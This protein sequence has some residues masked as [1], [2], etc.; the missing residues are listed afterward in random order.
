MTHRHDEVSLLDNYREEIRSMNAN[1]LEDRRA[2]ARVRARIDDTLRGPD[3]FAAERR[4]L[5]GLMPAPEA[6]GVDRVR[7][8]VRI[9]LTAP[10]PQRRPWWVV[11]GGG[12]LMAGAAAAAVA[13]VAQPSAQD[14]TPPPE[15]APIALAVTLSSPDR[16]EAIAPTGELALR[17]RG[18]GALTGDAAAPRL[19]WEAGAIEVDLAPHRG[20]DLR[21]ETREALVEV[22]G[23]AFSVERGPMGTRV[24]VTDGAVQV[25]CTGEP[26]RTL[27]PGGGALSE[28][29]CL[30]ITAA[31]LLGRARAQ[32]AGG[33]DADAVLETAAMGMEAGGIGADRARGEL[34]LLRVQTLADAGRGDEALAAADAWLEGG[35][36]ARRVEVL[37][38]A[39]RVALE[40]GC[41]A[42]RPWLVRLAE[43]GGEASSGAAARLAACD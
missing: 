37:T 28:A 43:A 27:R 42:A 5:L 41:E 6:A 33:A 32:R 21:V 10:A 7:R 36:D 34:A 17:Y 12:L 30:P 11:A 22:V 15:A 2:V 39:A 16:F 29:D 38:V 4:V 26:A 35:D 3:P 20:V 18:Q 14:P 25:T 23:T 31:G 9:S 1:T 40:S 8:R 24:A 19:A 13:L